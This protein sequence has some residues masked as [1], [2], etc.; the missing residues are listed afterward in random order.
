[1]IRT[2]TILRGIMRIAVCVAL[3]GDVGCKRES[4]TKITTFPA[5]NEA[6]GWMK[7]SD[8]RSFEAADLWKYVD[9]EAENS[10]RVHDTFWFSYR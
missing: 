1:M 9:G 2:H 7:T 8:I 5:S 6:L 4:Q 3:L 10:L